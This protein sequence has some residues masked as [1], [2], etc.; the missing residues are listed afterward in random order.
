MRGYE[1]EGVFARLE[2]GLVRAGDTKCRFLN[3]ALI[4]RFLKVASPLEV[5]ALLPALRCVAET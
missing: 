1:A 2:R 4:S 3:K 5:F